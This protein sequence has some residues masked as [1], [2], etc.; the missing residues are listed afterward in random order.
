MALEELPHRSAVDADLLMC[1]QKGRYIGAVEAGAAQLRY[2]RCVRPKLASLSFILAQAKKFIM[3][4]V[5]LIQ[6]G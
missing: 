4:H 3:F 6:S 1:E 5:C 2:Q